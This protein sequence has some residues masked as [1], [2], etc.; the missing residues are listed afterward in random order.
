MK[1]CHH[2]SEREGVEEEGSM[3]HTIFYP[4]FWTTLRHLLKENFPFQIKKVKFFEKLK[5]HVTRE[6]GGAMSANDT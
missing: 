3:C 1:Q 6:R 2:I 5:C 4:N